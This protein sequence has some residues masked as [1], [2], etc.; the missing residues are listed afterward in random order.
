MP[1]GHDGRSANTTRRPPAP[2]HEDRRL[3]ETFTGASA[4]NRS[5][6][7]A[8]ALD[9][10]ELAR[11]WLRHALVAI[12]TLLRVAPASFRTWLEKASSRVD[13]APLLLPRDA[14]LHLLPP[15]VG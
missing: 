9:V 15:S 7:F 1:S 8:H 6:N 5:L 11:L 12:A 10:D 3:A 4:Q 2:K 14:P 13:R